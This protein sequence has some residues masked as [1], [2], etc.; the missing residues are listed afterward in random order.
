MILKLKT[1]LVAAL[2]LAATQHLAAQ[3]CCNCYDDV[4][5][6][7]A[8]HWPSGDEIAIVCGGLKTNPPCALWPISS[9]RL[10][11]YFNPAL[12][13]RLHECYQRSFVT[14]LRR[15]AVAYTVTK[16]YFSA[17]PWCAVN[18]NPPP[19]CVGGCADEQQNPSHEDFTYCD[20]DVEDCH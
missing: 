7:P 4:R 17:T 9:C 10:G 13:A 2:C 19:G 12:P 11:V 16:H 1:G 14:H 3:E 8:P 6:I 20:I 15:V 5:E 18:E